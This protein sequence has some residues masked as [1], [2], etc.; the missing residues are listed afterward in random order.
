MR[1]GVEHRGVQLLEFGLVVES[2]TSVIHEGNGLACGQNP[3]EVDAPGGAPYGED[4]KLAVPSRALN[5]G[6]AVVDSRGGMAARS[7]SEG[8][9]DPVAVLA[10]KAHELYAFG[11]NAQPFPSHLH[12]AGKATRGHDDGLGVDADDPVSFLGIDA[13]DGPV[14]DDDVHGRGLDLEVE[15][16]QAVPVFPQRRENARSDVHPIT[17]VIDCAVVG[18]F[19]VAAIH[20]VG[21]WDMAQSMAL[22]L[23]SK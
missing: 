18:L 20:Q 9:V 3:V 8:H 10:F 7:G 22:P 12:I 1:W 16:I 23:K 2:H 11:W 19:G 17:L 5:G 14:L 15:V 6:K 21:P 4:G 13:L